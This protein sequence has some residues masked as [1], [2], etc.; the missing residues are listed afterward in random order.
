M[1]PLKEQ[2]RRFFVGSFGALLIVGLLYPYPSSVREQEISVGV[3]YIYHFEDDLFES[4]REDISGAMDIAL[5]RLNGLDIFH[6]HRF[7]YE[8]VGAYRVDSVEFGRG[9]ATPEFDENRTM[10]KILMELLSPIS[11]FR[12]ERGLY[13]IT[14]FVFPLAKC[15]SR[16]Y[17]I[18]TGGGSSPIFLSYN[19]LLAEIHFDRFTIEH[20]ILHI[21]GLPDRLCSDGVNCRY[22]D[23]VLSVMAEHP[24]KLYLSRGDYVDFEKGGL[25]EVDLLD[26]ATRH[27]SSKPPRPFIHEGADCPESIK[28]TREWRLVYGE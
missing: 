19:A 7:T 2:Y 5:G 3:Y 18:I 14:I 23:D 21:F 16:Q 26:V 17:A 1:S 20:E 13:N 25:G 15:V 10:N 4:W 9:S 22:P 6:G 11:S 24:D 8:V 27:G 28:P 12:E